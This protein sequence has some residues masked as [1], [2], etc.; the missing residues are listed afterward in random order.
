MDG[1]SKIQGFKFLF[2]KLILNIYFP[3]KE[4]YIIFNLTL[5]L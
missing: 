3:R 2:Q 5:F 4:A 1:V